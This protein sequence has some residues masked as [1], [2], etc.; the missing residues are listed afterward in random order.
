M[1]CHNYRIYHKNRI[2]K[3]APAYVDVVQWLGGFF[4]C[5]LYGI[6]YFCELFT[7]FMQKNRTTNYGVLPTLGLD[8]GPGV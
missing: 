5:Y 2:C 8:I 6:R 7:L 3:Y 1:I 4:L